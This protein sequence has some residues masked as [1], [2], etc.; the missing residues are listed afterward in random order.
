MDNLKPPTY[1]RRRIFEPHPIGADANWHDPG[2]LLTPTSISPTSTATISIA[3]NTL[4]T[5][6]SGFCQDSPTQRGANILGSPKAY[7][8]TGLGS[9]SLSD[10]E[11]QCT[12]LLNLNLRPSQRI[13]WMTHWWSNYDKLTNI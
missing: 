10:R 9:A 13:R 2:Y 6:R 3:M 5:T 11:I 1:S 8:T 12:I 7:G 4:T